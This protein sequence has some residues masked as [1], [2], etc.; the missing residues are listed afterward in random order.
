MS[1]RKKKDT[2]LHRMN[3]FEALNLAKEGKRVFRPGWTAPLEVGQSI[4]TADA[5]ADDWSVAEDKPVKLEL[6]RQEL[7]FIAALVG[8]CPTIIARHLFKVDAWDVYNKIANIAREARYIGPHALASALHTNVKG[9][10][11]NLVGK[12]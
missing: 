7:S 1:T 6:T 3:F 9:A 4:N 5:V 12:A 11:I 8:H 10:T 2:E